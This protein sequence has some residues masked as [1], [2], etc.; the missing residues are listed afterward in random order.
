MSKVQGVCSISLIDDGSQVTWNLT[1]N[2]TISQTWNN[3]VAV[4]DFEI[5]RPTVWISVREGTRFVSCSSD[6]T[7]KYNGETLVFDEDGYNVAGDGVQAGVFFLTEHNLGTEQE[8]INVPALQIVKNLANESE[9]R[10]S[11]VTFLG[12]YEPDGGGSIP[13]Q[14]DY[15]IKITESSDSSSYQGELRATTTL[16]TDETPTSTI[17]AYLWKPDGTQDSSSFITRWSIDDG[18]HWVTNTTHSFTLTSD[19]VDDIATVICQF[20][21]A[22]TSSF[23]GTPLWTSVLEIDDT[24]DEYEMQIQSV[25]TK[26]DELG[27]ISSFGTGDSAK[28]R[29]GD[30]VKIQF[31]ATKNGEPNTIVDLFPYAYVMAYDYQNNPFT[32]FLT[33]FSNVVQGTAWR[34]VTDVVNSIATLI[35]L[36]ENASAL[37]GSGSLR[38]MMC[39]EQIQADV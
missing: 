5:T 6:F 11:V 17:T 7:W 12:T 10:I 9:N 15:N 2:S 14:D 25:L 22:N 13:L 34:P 8:P 16:L 18:A 20:W 23:A 33:G 27:N 37:G 1:S 29:N 35:A 26:A 21:P 38:F 4:P 39:N 28:L 3:G 19:D 32:G 24:V 36:Y 30:A 31:Y